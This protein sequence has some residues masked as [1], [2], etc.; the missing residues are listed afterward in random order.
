MPAG[1]VRDS[2]FLTVALIAATF[3]VILGLF[4]LFFLAAAEKVPKLWVNN[5]DF[6]SAS[7]GDFGAGRHDC[8][9]SFELSFG[10]LILF[11]L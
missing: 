7:D 8:G 3:G 5:G 4:G 11:L 9:E 2:Q 6:N 1:F 10:L